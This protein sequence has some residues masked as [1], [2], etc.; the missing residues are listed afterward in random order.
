MIFSLFTTATL[1]SLAH[2]AHA[3]STYTLLEPLPTITETGASVM[4]KEIN[5]NDYINYAINLLIAISAAAAVFMIVWG[6]L[7]Y[8]TTD[9]WNGKSE[10]KEKVTNAIIGLLMVL[11]TYI[12]LKTV[13]P[14]LVAIPATLVPPITGLATSSSK[15]FY[16]A[17]MADMNQIRGNNSQAITQLKNLEATTKDL[18]KQLSDTEKKFS[19]AGCRGVDYIPGVDYLQDNPTQCNQIDAEIKAINVKIQ[20]NAG[21]AIVIY[22][23]QSMDNTLLTIDPVHT[24]ITDIYSTINKNRLQRDTALGELDAAG[25]YDRESDIFNKANLNEAKIAIQGQSATLLQ[26]SGG[27]DYYNPS[28]DLK[29]YVNNTLANDLKTLTTFDTKDTNLQQ[30]NAVSNIMVIQEYYLKLID[31]PVLKR[32]LVEYG[33]QARAPLVR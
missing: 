7:L 14:A 32:Q 24:P 11:S 10:G 6:G 12:I 26:M 18:N 30:D 23:N 20:D 25:A 19:D 33:K 27:S 8:M 4:G 15:D 13:N 31:D 16:N 28:Q 22:A 17:L 1:V 2:P 5:L 21:Q 29:T 3:Q 9:S